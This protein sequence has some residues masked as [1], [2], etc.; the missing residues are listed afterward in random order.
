M[1]TFIDIEVDSISKKIYDF[2]AIKDNRQEF[3]QSDLK[4]FIRFISGS[5]FYCGHNIVMHDSQFLNKYQKIMP[6]IANKKMIDTL[7]L[8][9]LLFTEKPYHHLTKDDKLKPEDSNNPLNDAKNAMTLFYDE[10]ESFKHLDDALKDIFAYL[11]KDH[12]GFKGF[13]DFINYSCE[14]KNI[15][16]LIKSYFKDKIC[17]DVQMDPYVRLYPVELAYTLALINTNNVSSLFPQWIIKQYPH[18]EGIMLSLK[19]TPCVDGC[20]YCEHHLSS[21]YGLKRFFGYESYRAYKG[22]KLQEKAVDF[23]LKNESLLAVFP[24]GGG[25]SVTFQVPA[26]MRGEVT[27]SLTVVISPLQSLMKDQVDNLEQKNITASATLNGLLDPIERAKEIERVKNGEVSILYVSPESLRSYSI[28][29]LISNRDITRFVI[30][31]AHC[32]SS[33]GHDFRPDYLYIGDFIKKIQEKKG[34]DKIIPVSCFTATA[35]KQVI[36]EIKTYFKDKLN[37]D[38]HELV[39][40]S[41]RDNLAY[42]VIP[43]EEEHNKYQ[44][45]KSLLDKHSVPTI[46]YASRVKQVEKLYDSL[47]KDLYEV[48]KFHAKMD[49]D[50]KISHQDDFMSG[51]TNI[52][53]ATTAFGMG[54]DKSDVGVV[55]HY[56]ISDSIE[57]YIQESGRAGR[58]QSI[59]ATCYVLYHK[60]DLDKHFSLLNATKLNQKEIQQ[61][62]SGIKK[63]TSKK[64]K[65][66][67]SALELAKAAGWDDSI[68][69]IQTRVV[70]AL[71][72]LEQNGYIKRGQNATKIFASSLIAKNIEDARSRLLTSKLFIDEKDLELAIRIVSRL[73]TE[74]HSKSSDE[75]SETRVDYLSDQLGIPKQKVIQTIQLLKEAKVLDDFN[76]MVCYL[77]KKNELNAASK[78]EAR[79]RALERFL[80]ERMDDEQI[81][82]NL[83]KLNEDAT[84]SGLKSSVKDFKNIMN[85]LAITKK[86][87]VTKEGQDVLRVQRLDAHVLQ[88]LFNIHEIAEH[89]ITYLYNQ[90]QQTK[91]KSQD[92]ISVYFS[93]NA[94]KKY[95]NQQS[96]LLSTNNYTLQ[97]IEDA[98][99]YLKKIEALKI[100]GG[101]LVLYSPMNITRIEDNNNKK[102]TKQ[103]YERLSQFYHMRTQQIHIVGE[104]A[105]MMTKNY[106]QALTFVNDYFQM[107]YDQFLNKYFRGERKKDIQRNL[108]KAKFEE[109]F[110]TLSP[111]QLN[112]IS[113]KDSQQ[114]VVGAGPGSGKTKLLVHKLASIIL[115][116]D[117][118][119]EQL[120]MLTFSRAAANEF[121]E[122]LIQLI[123]ETA[124]YIDIKTF[125]S[126]CFDLLGQVGNIEK[127]TNVIK[128]AIDIIYSNDVDLSKITKMV[129]V[130]DE[131]QDMSQDEYNLVKALKHYNEDLRIIA[132]GDDDQNIYEFR[133]SSSDYMKALIDEGATKYEL[134]TNYR[135]KNNLVSFTNQFATQ[136][137]HRMKTNHLTSHTKDHGEIVIIQ[138]IMQEQFYE[139]MV[140][141]YN[142]AMLTGTTAILTR[143]NHEATI[144]QGLFTLH[145]IKARLIQSLDGFS[146][147]KM[148]EFRDFKAIIEQLNE[149]PIILKSNWDRALEIFGEKHHQSKHIE[150]CYKALNT[151]YSLNYKFL[152]MS[153]LEMFLRE[154]TYEDFIEES[155]VYISTMHKSKG[156]EFDNVMLYYNNPDFLKEEEKRVLYVALTRAKTNLFIHTTNVMF[157][158]SEKVKLYNYK[159]RYETPQRLIYQLTHKDVQ[160]GYFKHTQNGIQK[161][162][163]GSILRYSDDQ[164]FM[165]VFN[166][167]ILKLSKKY[168]DDFENIIKQGYQLKEVS[169]NYILYWFNKGLSEGYDIV[170]PELVFE[171]T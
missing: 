88:Y 114:I 60:D 1:I 54:V 157:K 127:N 29:R 126:Y 158:E 129:L 93:V 65:I 121:K 7:L 141:H 143:N 21:T 38:L 69:D 171:K 159:V 51:K 18:V 134:L 116:E 165:N 149:S 118:C 117:I 152:Y 77:E 12:I 169:V 80:L 122:R 102:Y 5:D 31:E 13:F 70:T 63:L 27:R 37:L 82:I 95:L 151:F 55:I 130:I 98:I 68:R 44:T 105:D 96:T 72:E 107:D 20:H 133:G 19:G 50:I 97:E 154:S 142:K 111:A 2:G 79:Y 64:N 144:I 26:L 8:S 104:Y 14:T 11:L 30:D 92:I 53:I 100:E 76:D 58:D 120:L 59:A 42:Q 168:Q 28:E 163:A 170:I 22:E 34:N 10:V 124:F 167:K 15:E 36:E 132:V 99:Y 89:I 160:L 166:Y 87:K 49:R 3:H 45:L 101:F 74:Y 145:G 4:K 94:V 131:A 136:L 6:I 57:N 86:F 78:V 33:W 148:I 71:A 73:L 156:R 125:H 164:V 155:I 162:H 84:Q 123:G 43:I 46:I 90:E 83:K 52:M 147:S 106:D 115:T 139:A 109:I 75:A 17:N 67:Q 32:F 146:I 24:T 138:H 40:T 9:A 81:I 35:K 110:G 137:K 41:Q 85:Y 62:W 61:I 25:K 66:S 91:E 56:D 113:D 119:S 153:E 161:I 150:L 16:A 47:K 135:S 112:I 23:A 108:S 103:D 48:S 39:T 140:K 128:D